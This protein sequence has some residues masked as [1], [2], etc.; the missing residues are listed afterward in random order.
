M[1]STKKIFLFF[2][3]LQKTAKLRQLKKLKRKK[4][5]LEVRLRRRATHVQSL[6]FSRRLTRPHLRTAS[7]I[8]VSN[9][10]DFKEVFSAVCNS[11]DSFGP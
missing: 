7:K 6:P 10:T 3:K 1:V 5:V 2:L 8:E 4:F 11:T 9:Q